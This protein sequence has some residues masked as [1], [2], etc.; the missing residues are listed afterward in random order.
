V[1]LFVGGFVAS[2]LTA[3]ENKRDAA[4]YGLFVWAAVFAMLLFLVAT[5]VRAGFGA[6]VGVATASTA[7]AD[8]AARH[9]SQEDVEA[10][11]RRPN[12]ANSRSTSS[13]RG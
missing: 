5:G 6:M 13:R 10:M 2:Q 3:G 9:T 4:L 1:C 11:F 12:T 8:T 7:V